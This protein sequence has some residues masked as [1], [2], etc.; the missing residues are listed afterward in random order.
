MYTI[1]DPEYQKKYPLDVDFV[2]SFN[3]VTLDVRDTKNHGV[4]DPIVLFNETEATSTAKAM[5]TNVYDGTWNL[6]QKTA[7]N[8]AITKVISERKAGKKVGFWHVIELLAESKISDVK[9]M[10]R[11]LLSTIKGSVLELAFSHGEVEGLSF[12]KK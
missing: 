1:N 6:K 10:G 12:D 4:L 2:K 11:F 5:I 8:E 7:S 3:F 9:D